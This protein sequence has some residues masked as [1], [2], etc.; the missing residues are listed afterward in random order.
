[1]SVQVKIYDWKTPFNDVPVSILNESDS[2]KKYR[3]QSEDVIL[4]YRDGVFTGTA[5]GK[6][7]FTVEE[8]EAHY[9][10]KFAEQETADHVAA[11]RMGI[12]EAVNAKLD[13]LIMTEVL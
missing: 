3:E 2:W 5:H 9:E 6:G 8:W 10:E 12:I 13:F 4:V 1:M 11:A 7:A